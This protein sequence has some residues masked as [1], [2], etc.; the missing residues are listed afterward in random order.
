MRLSS[1]PLST[2]PL[3]LY[4]PLGKA[5][6]IIT[7]PEIQAALA[8]RRSVAKSTGGNFLLFQEGFTSANEIQ[9][10]KVDG[11]DAI[12]LGEE[13]GSTVNQV[14]AESLGVAVKTFFD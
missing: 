7:D 8:S 3:N 1:S 9:S 5:H 4:E 13:L 10:A 6:R 11:V 12:V 2:R 14:V